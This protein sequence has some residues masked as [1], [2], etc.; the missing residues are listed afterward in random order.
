MRKGIVH[1]S[2]VVL[3][4]LKILNKMGPLLRI[5]YWLFFALKAAE[6]NVESSAM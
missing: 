4:L 2:I 3:F 1:F 5:R 6:Y